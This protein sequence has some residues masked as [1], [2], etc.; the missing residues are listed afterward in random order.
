LRRYTKAGEIVALFGVDCKSGDTFTDG[1]AFH[2]S[3]S[4]LILRPFT[5]PL[6]SS[7]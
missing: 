7:S 3:T 2:Q 5:C 4:L 6:L 1:K